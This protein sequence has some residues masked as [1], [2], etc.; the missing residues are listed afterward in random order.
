MNHKV[1]KI[2][3]CEI[4]FVKICLFVKLEKHCD[5]LANNVVLVTSM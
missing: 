3:S 2:E 5:I 1:T 4:L